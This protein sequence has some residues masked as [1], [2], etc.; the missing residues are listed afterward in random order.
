MLPTLLS[1]M[2][3]NSFINQMAPLFSKIDFE[4]EFF[5]FPKNETYEKSHFNLV[6]GV[7]SMSIDIDEN[8]KAEDVKIDLDKKNV[9]TVQYSSETPMVKTWVKISENVPTD[10]DL[11]TLDANIIG[12]K[13][14][15]TGNKM[16]VK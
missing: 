4:N 6:G 1:L 5:S 10:M 12:N 7:Y 9:L 2:G 13:L 3:D 15:I 11:D 16:P 8:V 14:I